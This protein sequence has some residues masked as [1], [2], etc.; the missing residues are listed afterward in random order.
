M[1]SKLG[2]GVCIPGRFRCGAGRC[3][4]LIA[5]Q[6]VTGAPA[7]RKVVYLQLYWRCALD[8]ESVFMRGSG[9]PTELW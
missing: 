2:S 1:R 3:Y 9:R 8:R 6:L 5:N 4:D 7:V